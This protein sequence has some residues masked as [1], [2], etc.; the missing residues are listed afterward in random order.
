MNH[1]FIQESQAGPGKP[2]QVVSEAQPANDVTPAI[3][4]APV[5]D[6]LEVDDI[7]GNILAGFNKDFQRFLFLKIRDRN[8][9]KDW[10]RVIVPT[11]SSVA[12]VQSFNNL[13]RAMRARRGR[14][15]RGLVAT[16]MNIA[17]TSAG[18]KAL[19]SKTEV[20]KFRE[21]PFTIGMH[22]RA[23]FLGDPLDANG[24]P[25]NWV[26]GSPT[27]IP[28]ILL[29][30]ASDDAAQLDAKV[31]RVKESIL[32]LPKPKGL[33][34]P[35]ALELLY[36]Q[37][38]RVRTDKPGHEH[39]GFKDGISQP[40]IRGRV[41]NEAESLLTRRLIDPQDERAVRFGKPGQPL[42]WPG[43]FVL[44]YQRQ[45]A[46]DALN[47]GPALEPVPP[48]TRNGSYLV[49]RRLVQDVPAF[50]RFV[51][52]KATELNQKPGFA[53]M[54][55]ER[56]AT[57]L[58]G[59]WES[60]A[61]V[62]RAP[63][64]DDPALAEDSLANNHFRY[65]NPSTPVPLLP[66]PGYSGDKFAQ[67]TSDNLGAICPH[68]GH[69]R[70][71]NPRDMSTDSGGGNDNLTRLML[72]RGI[73]FG[74]QIVD[75]F[76]PTDDELQSERGLMFLSYQTS[77]ERQFEFLTNHWANVE[78]QP[79]EGGHDPIIGQNATD[80][81]RLRT[82]TLI[83]ET[84]ETVQVSIPFEWITPTGGGYFFAPSISAIKTVLGA[85]KE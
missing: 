46:N 39:F 44:G 45:R 67:A 68:A 23:G 8:I 38:G 19:T 82:V 69:I 80:P 13:F 32:A 30:I 43:Q 55:G 70:K 21:T 59:R 73:P 24:N 81:N 7:Q 83:G 6:V 15:A 51:T 79:Q 28:D 1:S 26:I 10:L 78:N 66:I 33:L 27:N 50:W 29:I 40:G 54:T 9:V 18:I 14:E 75:P 84:G 41:S 42:I 65:V 72:R 85:G 56:L 20:D 61:P 60:G 36:E 4:G 47:P 11:I 48:W 22:E 12:E 35:L 76:H 58:V 71:S 34:A 53:N 25:A 52:A 74:P 49:V 63:S 16:W 57:L 64:A 2:P 37:A 17:F 5:E 77:I 3:A 31:T 62:M